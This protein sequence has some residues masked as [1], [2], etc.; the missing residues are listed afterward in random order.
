M[1]HGIGL[2]EASVLKHKTRSAHSMQPSP[3]N[4]PA[5]M[6]GRRILKRLAMSGSVILASAMSNWTNAYLGPIQG[7]CV[8]LLAFAL[9]NSED[10]HEKS[11]EARLSLAKRVCILYCNQQVRI[12]FIIRD[13]NIVSIFADIILAMILATMTII[14]N[15]RY[16]R[17]RPQDVGDI[18]MILESLLYLYGDILDS[19]FQYGTLKI[20][21]CAFGASMALKTLPPPQTQ[22]LQF[23]WRM[24]SIVSSNLLSEGL[25][26]L[27][28]AVH[29]LKI[30][31]ILTTV[32]VL[33]L[34]LPDME[35]Y[36]IYLAAQQLKLEL[37]DAAPFFVCVIVCLGFLPSSSREW[38]GEMCFTYILSAVA[39]YMS[40]VPFWGMIFVL[41]MVHYV[42]Y[43]L[44]SK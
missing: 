33:R 42:E 2:N 32:C 1:C 23:C 44:F 10:H 43:I 31:Q 28:P 7:L 30:L 37:P 25:S 26:M 17:G 14:V 40:W 16:T 8:A 13:N 36:L 3:P 20:T 24:A 5:M 38:V 34:I 6:L 39:V 15:E 41:A 22:M 27:I 11:I 12:L 19:A 29:G 35:Y 21:L 4:L 9:L 18:K